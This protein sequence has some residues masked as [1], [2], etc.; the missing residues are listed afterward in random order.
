MRE[1]T[2]KTTKTVTVNQM[3]IKSVT[4][5]KK[6]NDIDIINQYRME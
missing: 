2:F 5:Q 1:N 6:E 4:S 3:A